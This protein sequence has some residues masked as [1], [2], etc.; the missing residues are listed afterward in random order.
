M[1]GFHRLRLDRRSFLLGAS[2]LGFAPLLGCATRLADAPPVVFVHGNG[3][4]AALWHT[5]IWRFESNGF[6]PAR[7]HAIDFP[8]PLAR[9][10]DSV[11]QEGRSSTTEQREQLAAFVADVKRRTGAPKVAL[12]GSSRGGNAIRNFV[13]NGGGGAHVSHAV[14]CGTP[15]HGVVASDKVLVG[16]EFNGS[17]PFLKQ[18]NDGGNEVVPG[19]AWMTTRSDANDKYAQPDGRYLGFP[20]GSPTGVAFDGPA[21]KGAENVVLP[22]LDHREV[23]F[24]P[25]AFAAIW[26]FLT[27]DGPATTDFAPESAPVLNGKVS[28]LPKGVPSNLPVAGAA[29]EIHETDPKTG[30]RRALVHRQTT[31]ADGLWGPFRAR[32]DAYY[33]FVVAAPGEAIT[34]IYRAPFARSSAHVHLRPARL[35]DDD[36]KAGSS[37]TLTRPRGYFGKGRDAITVDGQPAP[38]IPD[39]VATVSTSTV[40]LPPGPPRAVVGRFN[41]ETIAARSW[42]TAENR[43]VLIEYH[44]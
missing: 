29:V 9:S 34:H 10:N 19:V 16:S 38:G 37:V 30:E 17:Q 22:G 8:W 6:D 14:L 25:Q 13:K 2:A 18:L 39:G 40:R 20:P 42:S 5:T 43:I 15:N 4:T 35:T 26:R 44:A 21:L 3:D 41:G 28:G 33:E 12:V 24:H 23:A 31:G 36:R 32:P 1:D 11:A 27:G 7:L